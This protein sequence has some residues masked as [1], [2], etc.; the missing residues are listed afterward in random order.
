MKRQ[1]DEL[2]IRE[3]PLFSH[4]EVDDIAHLF[5][6]F[7]YNRQVDWAS[8]HKTRAGSLSPTLE[9]Y[10]AGHALGSAGIMVRGK[11]ERLFF[12]GDVCFHD[13]TILKSAR[14]EDVRADVLIMETTRGNRAVPR[15]FTREGE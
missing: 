4:D 14:F 2:G 5:Q 11:K 3:Y 15:G 12:T 7:K 9:F 1:R 13:Q 6:G 8:F 10:D